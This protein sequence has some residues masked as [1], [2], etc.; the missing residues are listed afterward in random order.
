VSIS[1]ERTRGV[2]GENVNEPGSPSSTWDRKECVEALKCP[3]EGGRKGRS[4]RKKKEG[5]WAI[6]TKET[7]RECSTFLS[8]FHLEEINLVK[9]KCKGESR[10]R[11]EKK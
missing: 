10:R 6:Q 2:R 7:R 5:T 4:E 1:K 9:E 11:E 8:S 3:K